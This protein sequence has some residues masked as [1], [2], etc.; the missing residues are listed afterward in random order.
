[1]PEKR[2]LRV[3]SLCGFSNA[4]LNLQFHQLQHPLDDHGGESGSI[5]LDFCGDWSLIMPLS[6]TL[7]AF[8]A[9]LAWERSDKKYR[10]KHV[11]LNEDGDM[12]LYG[13]KYMS[14]DDDPARA[15]VMT[16]IKILKLNKR[17]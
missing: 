2:V 3:N 4:E 16:M 10:A 9:P 7:G 12:A 15:L 8:V 13:T 17:E 14:D 5:P 6:I 11:T 1:M